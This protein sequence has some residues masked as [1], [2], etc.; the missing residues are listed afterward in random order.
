MC[1][2]APPKLRAASPKRPPGACGRLKAKNG[3]CASLG[4]IVKAAL[5]QTRETLTAMER[6]ARETEAKFAGVADA[7]ERTQENL[8]EAHAQLSET[9]TAVQDLGGMEALEADLA[10]AQK[11]AIELSPRQRAKT[12]LISLEREH[13]ARTERQAAIAA[14]CERWKTRSAGAHQQ[15][16]TL[17]QR[18]AEASPEI[19]RLAGLPAMVE[20]QRQKL[21]T[22]PGKA[23]ADRQAAA[24]ALAAAETAHR[25]AAQALRAAQGAVADER[26]ARA[27]AEARLEAAR[28]R[29][30]EEARKI[31]DSLG[32]APE[33]CLALAQLEA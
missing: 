23:E 14:E 25:E 29:R 10:A 3:A 31:R 26:E 15:I 17:Q 22:E 32:C 12:E 30:S 11:S 19:E 16:A 2:A 5:T 7:K 6:Q 28:V 24:D 13:R 33:A 9:E 4:G 1:S 27:R 8:L 18:V 20:Q 21:M